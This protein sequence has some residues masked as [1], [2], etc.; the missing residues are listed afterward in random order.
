MN[1]M[2]ELTWLLHVKEVLKCNIKSCMYTTT[3]GYL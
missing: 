1:V 3:W 2:P